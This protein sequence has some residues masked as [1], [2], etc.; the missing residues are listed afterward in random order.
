MPQMRPMP[1]SVSTR[2]PVR[3]GT[4]TGTGASPARGVP[5]DTGTAEKPLSLEEISLYR[6]VGGASAGSENF[7]P[8]GSLLRTQGRQGV[9]SSRACSLAEE[10][11]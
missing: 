3:C 8:R 6:S 5:A 10:P 9:R 7:P 1:L 4:Y 2:R 11:C